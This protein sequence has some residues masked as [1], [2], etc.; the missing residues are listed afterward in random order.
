M[1][2]KEIAIQVQEMLAAGII[3]PCSPPYS[4]PIAMVKKKDEQFRFYMDY[5]RLNALTRDTAQHTPRIQEAL[6]DLG[7]AE[8]FSRLDLKSGC[9]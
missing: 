9:W 4:S 5:Q 3:E 6:M 2:R 8:V 1:K 7:D